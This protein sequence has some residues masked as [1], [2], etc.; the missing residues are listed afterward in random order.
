MSL[1]GKT[2]KE[3][4]R[5]V[6]Q[7]VGAPALVA[8]RLFGTLYYD[9]FASRDRVVH[10]G[11]APESDSVAI[12]AIYPVDGL[13]PSHI[14]AVDWL[15]A[16][17]QETIVVCNLPLAEND[18]ATLSPK[19]S[20]IITRPNVGYDFGAYRDGVLHLAGRLE[21]LRSLS[22]FNDSTWFPVTRTNWIAEAEALGVDYA[23]ATS[24]FGT[25]ASRQMR[26]ARARW[27][28]GHDHPNFH[29]A[30]YALWIGA[31]ILR[32]RWF[33][34]YWRRYPLTNSKHRTVRRGEIGLTRRVKRSGSRHGCTM[35]PDRIK[36]HVETLPDD[37]LRELAGALIA[38]EVRMEVIDPAG[39]YADL[40]SLGRDAL[41]DYILCVISR[42]GAVY[43]IPALTISHM[44]FPFL[45]KAP[46]YIDRRSSEISLSVAG[47]LDDSV[48]A[49]V[50]PE[51]KAL[52]K[53]LKG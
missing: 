21:R 37:R 49:I 39:A 5:L 47:M 19:V 7:T 53:R 22:L 38:P 45:K 35:S 44:D 17:G 6:R 30:S 34:P 4:R 13:M 11:Q 23:S 1:R 31:D 18:I 15:N 20:A 2:A 27:V 51:A 48:K 3:L 40:S 10:A 28:Y 36:A 8:N 43:A 32:S 12:Y 50:L 24:H 9:H 25:P 41:L 52:I 26:G 42:Q 16:A 33:L 29:Y 46:F 14:H